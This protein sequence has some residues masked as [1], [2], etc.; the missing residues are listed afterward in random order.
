MAPKSPPFPSAEPASP[1]GGTQPLFPD[2]LRKVVE[3]I[4]TEELPLTRHFHGLAHTR[5]MVRVAGELCRA[6]GMD[7]AGRRTVETAALLLDTGF[8]EATSEPLGKSALM[9]NLLLPVQGYALAEVDAVRSLIELA[10]EAGAAPSTPEQ[11]VLLDV[12]N[13]FAGAQ[14]A[15]DQFQLLYREALEDGLFADR[16]GFL[17]HWIPR[18][19]QMDYHTDAAK[20]TFAANKMRLRMK[21][22]REL[23]GLRFD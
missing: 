11:Q 19:K 8:R 14:D 2:S 7:D 1:S 9:A 20:E 10:A 18:L 21:L 17:R 15:D 3:A 4:L 6:E 13:E 22:E 5:R 23:A 12:R 16:A